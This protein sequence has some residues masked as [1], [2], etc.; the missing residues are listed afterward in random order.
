MY[1]RLVWY[2]GSQHRSGYD[3][4]INLL[5]TMRSGCA[6]WRHNPGPHWYSLTAAMAKSAK[7]SIPRSKP[8][9]GKK[10][11]WDEELKR[12]KQVARN[13]Y[14]MWRATGKPRQG[15]LYEAC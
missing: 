12:L 3:L 4:K 10:M 9:R 6:S 11:G 7:R 13:D 15:D 5:E 8:R 14:C 1:S 2:S